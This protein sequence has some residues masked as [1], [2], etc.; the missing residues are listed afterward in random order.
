MLKNREQFA[1]ICLVGLVAFLLFV[2][3]VLKDVHWAGLSAGDK[4]TWTG[5]GVAFLA[6]VAAVVAAWLNKK[7]SD[8]ALQNSAFMELSSLTFI[9]SSDANREFKDMLN[10]IRSEKG[11]PNIGMEFDATGKIKEIT[12][13]RYQDK[14]RTCSEQIKKIFSH[15]VKMINASELDEKKKNLIVES[16]IDS[17]SP[18]LINEIISGGETIFFWNN[19]PTSLFYRGLYLQNYDAI[20]NEI[21]R[22]KMYTFHVEAADR[23]R[24][25]NTS[26]PV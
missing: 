22:L 6:L 11:K 26:S 13:Q 17:F 7:S 16:F 12:Y 14:I 19:S 25:G 5:S 8:Q 18:E 23:A 3:Y 24:Y 21:R 9:K 2:G 20:M 10:D 1:T 4:A 15:T